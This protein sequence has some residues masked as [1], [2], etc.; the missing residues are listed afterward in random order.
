MDAAAI[1]EVI[2]ELFDDLSGVTLE[3]LID[4]PKA[5]VIENNPKSED[6]IRYNP[7]ALR[8]R[9]E[10]TIIGEEAFPKIIEEYNSGG[11]TAAYD[12]LRSQHGIRH[13]YFVINQIKVCGKYS[14]DA[15]TDHFCVTETSTAD[16]VFMDL[17]KLCNR[18][19]LSPTRKTEAV[20]DPRPAAMERLVHELISDRLLTL[21]RYITLDSSTKTILIDQ[22]SLS[23]DGYQVVTH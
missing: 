11:K 20:T 6:E 19:T 16:S 1:Y 4:N 3:L 12:Y 22:T 7:Q 8:C 15:D 9:M 10:K 17:D 21:S 14:Y 13:P 2:Q 18:T 5:L 23:A